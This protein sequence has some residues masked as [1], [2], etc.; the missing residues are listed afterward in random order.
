[1]VRTDVSLV[2][3]TADPVSGRHDRTVIN[4]TW[5]LGEALVSGMV[6][7]DHIVTDP[8]GKILDY[9][10]GDKRTMVIAGAEG[11]RIVGVPRAL[12]RMSVLATDQVAQVVATAQR[13]SD[14]LGFPADIEAGFAGTELF[15]FQARPITTLGADVAPPELF[16]VAA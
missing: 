2:A 1:M 8:S 6:T 4:A 3:F 7:P 5:G 10:P 14:V 16:E 15:L 13:V 9:Q 12:Q 11:T